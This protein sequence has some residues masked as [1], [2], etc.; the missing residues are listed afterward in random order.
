[1][2]HK[3]LEGNQRETEAQVPGD[4]EQR[5][6]AAEPLN[7]SEGQ[8]LHD[9][10]GQAEAE[11]QPSRCSRRVQPDRTEQQCDDGW[12]SR[13]ENPALA[14]RD[15]AQRGHR[16]ML[17]FGHPLGEEVR[18]HV[19]DP[20]HDGS[21]GHERRDMSRSVRIGPRPGNDDRQDEN[22]AVDESA[23]TF[24]DR[25]AAEVDGPGRAKPWLSSTRQ[26]RTPARRR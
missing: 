23:K 2:G 9:Q 14:L 3:E 15:L 5:A 25:R 1:M 24:A 16:E 8:S 13:L 12:H 26:G 20:E 17:V 22:R 4:D 21:D 18:V 7:M 19:R 6:D 11:G 10:H